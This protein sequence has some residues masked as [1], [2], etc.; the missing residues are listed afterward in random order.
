[1]N[2]FVGYHQQIKMLTNLLLYALFFHLPMLQISLAASQ[3][4]PL[5]TIKEGV[6]ITTPGCQSKCGNLN[7]PYPFGIGLGSGCS[8]DPNFDIDCNTFFNPP[9]PYVMGDLEVVDISPSNS[10]LRVKNWLASRCFNKWGNLSLS[11]PF[12]INLYRYFSFSDVNKFTIVGCD[13]FVLSKA[14]GLGV[15]FSIGCISSCSSKENLLDGDCL[16]IG[17]CQT[18]IPKGLHNFSVDLLTLYSHERVLSFD[19]CGYA[20]LG[21]R[22]RYSFRISD[23]SDPAFKNR[24]IENVPI[25]IDWEVSNKTCAEARI[26]NDSYC[27]QNSTCIDSPI[28]HGGYSCNCFDGYEGN[29]YLEPGCQG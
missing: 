8:V 25:V 12:S 28:E 4:L 23:L 10:Q 13:D 24:T 26:S 1:M 2:A 7:V 17:C 14:L 21:D 19:P 29:P 22:D 27:H 11:N 3:E 15:N 16:G 9:K 18:S 5:T 20:F 6:N